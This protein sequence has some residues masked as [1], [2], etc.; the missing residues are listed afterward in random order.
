MPDAKNDRRNF[1]RKSLTRLSLLLVAI[2][3][4]PLSRFSGFKPKPKPRIVMVNKVLKPGSAHLDGDFVLFAL[5]E[6]PVAVSRI[7]THL[8]CKLHYLATEAILE[9]PCHQSRF[10]RNGKRLAGPATRDLDTFPVEVK[11]DE[12]GKIGGYV[13]S[14]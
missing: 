10:S 13:V 11:Q 8:G 3:A 2:M 14:M 4:Y 5:E 9:C 7:C 12:S 1:L 6:G